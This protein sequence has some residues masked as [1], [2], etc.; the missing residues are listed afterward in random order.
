MK[1][2]T[3]KPPLGAH[4]GISLAFGHLY[5]NIGDELVFPAGCAFWPESISAP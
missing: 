5:A 2:T 3:M 1:K 4:R